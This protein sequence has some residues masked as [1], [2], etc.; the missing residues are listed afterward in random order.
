MTN[1]IATAVCITT[2][3]HLEWFGGKDHH[4]IKWL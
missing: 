3:H 4:I 2:A 1:V